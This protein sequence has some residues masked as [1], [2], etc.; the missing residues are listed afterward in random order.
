MK[1]THLTALDIQNVKRVIHISDIHIR[2]VKRHKEYREAFETLYQQIRDVCGMGPSSQSINRDTFILFT[3]DLFHTKIELSP[4][5][6]SLASDFLRR[7]SS[8]AP[9]LVIAGN[10]DMNLANKHRMDSFSPIIDNLRSDN[11]FYLRESG[12]YTIGDTDVGVF[13]IVG[14]ESE[15]PH[16]SDCHSENKIAVCHAPI[17]DATTDTGYTIT[18][19]HMDISLFDG[20]DMVMMGDIHKMQVLQDYDLHEDKP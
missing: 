2:L 19:R 1:R 16:A 14:E 7:L 9:I 8:I 12:V 5:V 11:I 4:E 20:Y 13:S 10:H 6:I 17:N 18:D 3:G 15:W